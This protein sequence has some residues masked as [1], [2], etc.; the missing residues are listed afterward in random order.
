M[1]MSAA[2]ARSGGYRAC[3]VCNP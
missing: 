3:K 1:Y 2:Q